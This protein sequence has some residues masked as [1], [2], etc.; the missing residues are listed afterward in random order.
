MVGPEP[1][2]GAGVVGFDAG[3]L[4]FGVWSAM[5]L[6]AGCKDG[7]LCYMVLIS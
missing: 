1:G 6:K 3:W 4:M 7:R 5:V 2:V